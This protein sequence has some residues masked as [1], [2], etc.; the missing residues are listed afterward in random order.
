MKLEVWLRLAQV[1][2]QT[3]PLDGPPRSKSGKVPYIERPDGSLL[4]D[5]SAIISVLSQEWSVTLDAHL[6]SAERARA[7]V[8]QRCFEENLYWLLVYERWVRAEGWQLTKRA[9]F[10]ALPPLLR[11]VIS[12]FIRRKVLRDAWGQGLARLSYAQIVERATHDF[13][14]LEAALG[15]QPYF[16]GE[17]PTSIDATAYAFLANLLLPPI[18]GEA[19]ERLSAAPNLVS[20][21]ERMRSVVYG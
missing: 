10:G 19:R 13:S 15:E 17:R 9:Y 11:D 3:L 20:Y 16:L 18:P 1:P 2:H 5:S 6:T 14:A 7:T 8:L 4:S 21:V 12:A